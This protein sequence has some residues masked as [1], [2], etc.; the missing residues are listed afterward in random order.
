MSK[1][2]LAWTPRPARFDR[3]SD[4]RDLLLDGKK[5]GEFYAHEEDGSV[6]SIDEVLTLLAEH[7][8]IDY[9]PI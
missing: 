9:A 5:I 3:F 6:G 1:P 2:R 7:G 4:P 8:A